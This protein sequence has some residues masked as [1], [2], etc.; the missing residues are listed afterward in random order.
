MIKQETTTYLENNSMMKDELPS[1]VNPLRGEQDVKLS[2]DLKPLWLACYYEKRLSKNMVQA[3]HLRHTMRVLRELLKGESGSDF[4]KVY[5]FVFGFIKILVRKF[6]F[7]I[8]ESNSTLESL[9]NPFAS[10]DVEEVAAPG[11]SATKRQKNP[12][13]AKRDGAYAAPQGLNKLKKNFFD[14]TNIKYHG[15]EPAVL[16]KI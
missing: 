15:I 4:K 1:H 16:D 7:L 13:L 12:A 14:L 2:E 11:G 8:S 3:V 9:N 10:D 6:N 5:P